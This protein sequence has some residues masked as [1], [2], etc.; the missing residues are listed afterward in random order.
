[1]DSAPLPLIKT[2]SNMANSMMKYSIPSPF[3]LPVQFIA[4][5]SE[6]CL[7]I[8]PTKIKKLNNAPILLKNPIINMILPNDC[9][10]IT[11]QAIYTGIFFVANEARDSLIPTPPPKSFHQPKSFCIPYGKIMIP[12]ITLIKVKVKL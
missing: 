1:M 9:A 11:I 12:E 10:S 7:N 8:A 4:H 2:N 3:L 6:E 5:P